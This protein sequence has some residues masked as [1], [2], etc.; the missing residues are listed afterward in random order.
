MMNI[1]IW[2]DNIEH[3][4]VRCQSMVLAID[5]TRELD[6]GRTNIDAFFETRVYYLC[7]LMSLS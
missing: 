5:T 3:L 6:N 7:P 1:F 2:H 4:E